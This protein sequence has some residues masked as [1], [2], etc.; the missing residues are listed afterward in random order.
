MIAIRPQQTERTRY[1]G[2][3]I[4]CVNGKYGLRYQGRVVAPHVFDGIGFNVEFDIVE[5]HLNGKVA[6]SLMKDI[7]I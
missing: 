4:E 6:P 7:P 1:K 2:F 5:F 3:R